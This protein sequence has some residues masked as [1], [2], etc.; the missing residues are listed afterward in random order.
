ML[1]VALAAWRRDWITI[2]LAIGV[3]AW[4]VIEIAFALHGWPGLARYM[5]EAAGGD[6]RPRRRA[7]RPSA[8][9]SARLPIPAWLGVAV[10]VVLVA[11]LAPT[12]ISHARDEHKDIAAQR[13]RREE[14]DQLTGVINRLGG[15]SRFHAC[16][17]P[18][19]RLEYQTILA[20]NLRVNVATVGYKYGPAVNTGRPIVLFTPQPQGGWVV[21]ALHQRLPGCASLPH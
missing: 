6:D 21:Q 14:I 1:S 11:S 15:P 20:W 12:A 3:V 8:D 13:V 7:R 16:G 2:V 19:T 9:R 4:V 18:L 10:V 17:E 5:F